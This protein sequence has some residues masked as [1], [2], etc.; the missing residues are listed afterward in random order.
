[1]E[2][3]KQTRR[4]FCN[5]TC[6]AAMLAALGGVTG[7]LQACGGGGSPTSPGGSATALPTVAGSVAGRTVTVAVD[8]GSPLAAAGSSALVRS[9]LGDFLVARTSQDAFSALSSVCTHEGNEITAYSGQIFVCPAHGAQF[10]SSGRVVAG[11]ARSALRSY[12]AQFAG[13]VLTINV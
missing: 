11:P 8:T 5:R 4:E 13:N 9:S 7:V 3:D 10:D 12:P 2:D 6:S 1:M